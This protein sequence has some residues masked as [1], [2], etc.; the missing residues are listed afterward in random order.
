MYTNTGFNLVLWKDLGL[1]G[2]SFPWKNWETCTQKW[3]TPK[4]TTP[5]PLQDLPLPL[6]FSNSCLLKTYCIGKVYIFGNLRVLLSYLG[7]HPYVSSWVC[8]GLMQIHMAMK[9]HCMRGNWYALLTCC[10]G[11]KSANGWQPWFPFH[12][13][14]SWMETCL[15][16]SEKKGYQ[17][18]TTGVH[19][20]KWY[21]F[22]D[23]TLFFS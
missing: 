12:P 9:Q 13:W 15:L 21:P 6:I 20:Y 7:D 5:C 1:G 4:A 18:G 10:G 14:W 17:S 22:S 11:L 2:N 3:T 8:D 19:C 16:H 23:R